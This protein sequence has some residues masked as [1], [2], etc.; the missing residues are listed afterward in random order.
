MNT[1]LRESNVLVQAEHKCRAL[2]IFYVITT[3]THTHT[4]THTHHTASIVIKKIKNKANSNYMPNSDCFYTAC[5]TPFLLRGKA[6]LLHPRPPFIWYS[7]SICSGADNTQHCCCSG[8]TLWT[9]MGGFAFQS[10]YISSALAGNAGGSFSAE[11]RMSKGTV[12]PFVV[13]E[14][15]IFLT[16]VIQSNACCSVLFLITVKVP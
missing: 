1:W 9:P 14:G 6:L 11:T 8:F 7:R 3:H 2:L 13:M 4:K 10:G 5:C 16:G 12:L 15:F